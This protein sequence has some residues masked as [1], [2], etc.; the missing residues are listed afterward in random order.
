MHELRTLVHS[1]D[2]LR[3]TTFII[4]PSYDGRP[5]WEPSFTMED[6]LGVGSDE[7]LFDPHLVA[8][9]GDDVVVQVH[10]DLTRSWVWGLTLIF[11]KKPGHSCPSSQMKRT[12]TTVGYYGSAASTGTF[13]LRRKCH[14]RGEHEKA[15]RRNWAPRKWNRCA[16]NSGRHMRRVTLGRAPPNEVAFSRRR[17]A[18]ERSERRSGRTENRDGP[19]YLHRYR[20]GAGPAPRPAT[21]FS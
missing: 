12:S 19:R 14:L 3:K 4:P 16:F 6:V 15:S 11:R 17:S 8:D 10:H 2:L 18:S 1:D 5:R 7:G 21:A 9:R 13:V 20:F